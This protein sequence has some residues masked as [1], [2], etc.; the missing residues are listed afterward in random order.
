MRKEKVLKP[1]GRYIIYY[2]FDEDEPRE[3]AAE[4]TQDDNSGEE[5]K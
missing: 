4:E 3:P 5:D 2:S 1:D